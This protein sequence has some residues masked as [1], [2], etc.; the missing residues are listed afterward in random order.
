M[1]YLRKLKAKTVLYHYIDANGVKTKAD[2]EV[3]ANNKAY[4]LGTSYTAYVKGAMVETETITPYK[5]M[6][7]VDA[8]HNYS[9][10]QGK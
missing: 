3:D 7:T 2:N 8:F 1:K 9:S 4:L 6:G 10:R 5:L